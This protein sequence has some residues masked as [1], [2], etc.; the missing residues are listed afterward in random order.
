MAVPFKVICTDG[1]RGPL[2]SVKLTVGKEYTVS[3]EDS[4]QYFL[5]NDLGVIGGYRKSRFKKKEEATKTAIL[6]VQ[7]SDQTPCSKTLVAKLDFTDLSGVKRLT[8]NRAY[9]SFYESKTSFTVR[10]DTGMYLEIHK[11]YFHAP[12]EPH[13]VT[14]G[15]EKSSPV[16]KLVCKTSYTGSLTKGRKYDV[17]SSQL[18]ITG[19]TIYLIIDDAGRKMPFDQ[20]FF[21]PVPESTKTPNTIIDTVT[22]ELSTMS[23]SPSKSPFDAIVSAV[24]H[25]VQV[26]AAQESA[27]LALEGAR[28]IFNSELLATEEG[29]QLC[30]MIVSG[31]GIYGTDPAVRAA[32]PFSIPHPEAVQAYCSWVMEGSTRDFVQPKMAIISAKVQELSGVFTEMAKEAIKMGLTPAPASEPTPVAEPVAVAQ[33]VKTEVAVPVGAK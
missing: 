10:D 2:G 27:D 4:K 3:E 15:E 18:G 7:R 22:K 8:N 26:A 13:V 12:A 20:S 1:E 28:K 24:K 30:K 9:V 19:G 23:N 21:E 14:P 31:L 16:S 33:T 5:V 29:R 32:L 6:P 17:V 25:G 11:D